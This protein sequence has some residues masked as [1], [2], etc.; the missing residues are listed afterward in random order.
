MLRLRI[1]PVIL[2]DTS[3]AC[4]SFLPTKRLV[5]LVNL[6]F[7]FGDLGFVACD[8]G[9]LVSLFV[10]A[11]QDA[12]GVLE[13]SAGLLVLDEGGRLGTEDQSDM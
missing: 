11:Q 1:N 8:L 7:T 12:G 13:F 2:C 10:C 4:G 6:V 9:T 3:P 5:A